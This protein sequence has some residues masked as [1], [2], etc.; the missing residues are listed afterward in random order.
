MHNFTCDTVLYDNG[1]DLLKIYSVA[2][3]KNRKG[4]AL[5]ADGKVILVHSNGE[6]GV[7][8][9]S[10]TRGNSGERF[11]ADSTIDIT[12]SDFNAAMNTAKTIGVRNIGASAMRIVFAEN[13]DLRAHYLGARRERTSFAMPW[14]RF[15]N[16]TVSSADLRALGATAKFLSAMISNG[17]IKEAKAP[18]AD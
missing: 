12:E 4:V 17:L 6:A 8:D 15:S 16:K 1:A 13:N 7:W 11:K 10:A 5:H 18:E 2:T 9:Q 3:G 14:V